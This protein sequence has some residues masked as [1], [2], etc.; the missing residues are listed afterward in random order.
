MSIFVDKSKTFKLNLYWK[1]VLYEGKEIDIEVSTTRREGWTEFSGEF[2]SA[3]AD[4][5]GKILA[6]TTIINSSDQKPLLNTHLLM[7]NV[8]T[9][10][11]VRWSATDAQGL[12]L[13]V[14]EQ[15]VKDLNYKIAVGLFIQYMN[16]TRLTPILKEAIRKE[17]GVKLPAKG[18]DMTQ[19]L[20]QN[21]AV[22]RA[23]STP[24]GQ[25]PGMIKSEGA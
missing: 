18:L 9:M 23:T 2:R 15:A 12:P 8:L 13:P 25:M 10:L 14:T 3:D 7:V 21:R 24:P 4:T 20:T 22:F 16:K 17:E 19:G 11:M 1:P 6:R 5:F